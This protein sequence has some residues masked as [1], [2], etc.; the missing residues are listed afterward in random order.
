MA[1]KSTL[2]VNAF[3]AGKV[4]GMALGN[5]F[6]DSI[7]AVGDLL[8]ALMTP[9]DYKTVRAQWCKGYA[10]AMGCKPVTAENQWAKV[11]RGV[12]LA[13]GFTKP[14]SAEAAKKAAQ[15]AAKKTNAPKAADKADTAEPETPAKGAET[16]KGV[17]MVLSSIE[18][19]IIAKL[20]AGQFKVAVDCIRR[21]AEESATAA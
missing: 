7:A 10:E 16:A 1:T 4:A 2:A 15:R 9:A 5:W 14:K 13:Y 12:E 17:Q 20:R 3:N 19:H 8:P 6:A 21:L 11:W 18:A